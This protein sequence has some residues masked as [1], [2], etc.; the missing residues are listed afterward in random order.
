MKRSA[1]ANWKGTGKEGKGVV[2]T[3]STVLNNTQYSFN[4]RFAEGVGTNPEELI[5]A[6]HSG[7]FAMKLSFVLNEAGFTAD[8]LTV[9]CTINFE[10]GAITNSHLD[11]TA[12]V[13]GITAEKFQACAADA[14]ANCPISKLL[15]TDITMEARLG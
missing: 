3:A 10:N 9:K 5:A 15:N 6:A 13:P 8:D 2:S 1:T 4:S 12:K 14:K 11:L 7:C